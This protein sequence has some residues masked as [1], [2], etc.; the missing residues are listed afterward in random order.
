VS[1]NRG[2]S[3]FY[4]KCWNCTRFIGESLLGRFDNKCDRCDADLDRTEDRV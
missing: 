3:K 1:G 2:T 4:V